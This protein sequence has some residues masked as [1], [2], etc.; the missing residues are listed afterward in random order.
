MAHPSRLSLAWAGTGI[1][2]RGMFAS[3]ALFGGY[4]I[5]RRKI[6]GHVLAAALGAGH[7]V[8]I[9]RRQGLGFVERLMAVMAG[10]FV[11]RHAGPLPD[12]F[13]APHCIAVSGRASREA[14]LGG[15][16]ICCYCDTEIDTLLVWGR[17]AGRNGNVGS[18]KQGRIP[19]WN[20]RPHNRF[21]KPI[22]LNHDSLNL[23][24][25]L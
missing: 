22:I 7:R 13:F 1:E 24:S 18:L 16:L 8:V 20:W 19:L 14:A 9:V 11:R 21:T 2:S 10:V 4:G 23:R 17:K 25:T 5:E 6:L 15:V 3:G 12:E